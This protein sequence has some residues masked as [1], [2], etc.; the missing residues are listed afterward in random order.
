MKTATSLT[1]LLKELES[2]EGDANEKEQRITEEIIF[3][4]GKF[5]ETEVR[6]EAAARTCQVV[7]HN[8]VETQA[9]IDEWKEKTRLLEEEIASM[10]DID[11]YE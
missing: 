7:E 1:L 3:M 6:A 4:E 2:K 5:K 10:N 11:D 9:E 8:L